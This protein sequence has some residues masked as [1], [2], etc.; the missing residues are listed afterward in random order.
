MDKQVTYRVIS[1]A[2][3]LVW[4]GTDTKR[5]ERNALIVAVNTGRTAYLQV[6]DER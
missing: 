4:T 2:H 1:E 6:G 5:A 3:G